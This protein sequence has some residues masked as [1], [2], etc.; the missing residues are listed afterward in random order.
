VVALGAG[1]L[2]VCRANAQDPVQNGGVRDCGIA[3][4]NPVQPSAAIDDV[5]NRSGGEIFMVDMPVLHGARIR[6]TPSED[7]EKALSKAE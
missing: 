1:I 6:E 4:L 3:Q 7:K 2:R 5:V